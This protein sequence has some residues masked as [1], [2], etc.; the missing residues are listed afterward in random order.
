LKEIITR[1]IW[2]ALFVAIIIGSILM[3]PYVFIGVMAIVLIVGLDEFRRL[4]KPEK[5][6]K[7]HLHYYFFGLTIY[8]FIALTQLD[9]LPVVYLKLLP[10][11]FVLLIIFELFRK[12]GASWHNITFY[13]TAYIYLSLSLGLMS[14]FYK[15]G[16]GEG[17]YPD[18]LIAMFVLVW[19][20]DVFAYLTGIF[21]GRHKLF[22]SISPKKT[23]EGSIGGLLFSLLFAYFIYTATGE[24]TLLQWLVLAV[25]VA[26]VGTLGD[27][28]ESLLKRNVGVKDSGKLMPGHG[29]I[30][31]RFDAV[32]FVVPFV[33]VYFNLV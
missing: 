33:Y 20:N 15:F 17:Y 28:A 14:A 27:L 21:F 30:L 1:T 22:E 19:A 6:R 23:W 2:G 8:L 29:G 9:V 12:K 4:L 25:L 10:V 5:K 3:G 24:M 13:F 11:F 31:D 16:Q 7:Y 32:L 26:V 18:I